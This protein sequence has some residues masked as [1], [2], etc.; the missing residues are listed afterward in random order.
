MKINAYL[1]FNGQ[2]AEA[3]RTYERVLGGKIT[4]IQTHGD[5]PMA[6]QTPPEM[7]DAV[8]HVRLEVDGQVLMGSDVPPEYFEKQQGMSVAIHVDDPAEAQ[9]VFDGLAEG[10]HVTMPLQKTFWAGR[11]G[12]LR[13]RFGT[14]WMVNCEK[15]D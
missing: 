9:R 15:G 6:G 4:F 3:F 1:N 8:M 12:M 13:D 11:F 14:P 7:R 5:S 10:G 2:C